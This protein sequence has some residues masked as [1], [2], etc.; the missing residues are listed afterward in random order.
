MGF[1]PGK[2]QTR[3]LIYVLRFYI[4]IASTAPSKK[5]KLLMCGEETLQLHA[6]KRT[7][8]RDQTEPSFY[9]DTSL[10]AHVSLLVLSC[11]GLVSK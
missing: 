8:C 3:L 5:R 11:C 6:F 7:H 1:R 2:T 9:S 4:V 10:D